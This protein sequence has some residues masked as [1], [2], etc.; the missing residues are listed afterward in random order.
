MFTW[1][2]VDFIFLQKDRDVMQ[3]VKCTESKL[4]LKWLNNSI[5]IFKYFYFDFISKHSVD[6]TRH[7]YFLFLRYFVILPSSCFVSSDIFFSLATTFCLSSLK[8]RVNN[9]QYSDAATQSVSVINSNKLDHFGL[10][11][12]EF[13]QVVSEM[14]CGNT[15]SG[16]KFRNFLWIMQFFI[17]KF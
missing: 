11:Q 16:D 9:F 3:V 12:I 17:V 5:V 15:K 10:R 14:V 8:L 2:I 6:R 7:R 1:I 13:I 4:L